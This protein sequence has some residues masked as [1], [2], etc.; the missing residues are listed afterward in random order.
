MLKCC[1]RV[2][3]DILSY[4]FNP[5]ILVA[6]SALAI[7]IEVFK[8]FLILFLELIVGLILIEIL[9]KAMVVSKANEKV[10]MINLKKLV[11]G[12]IKRILIYFLNTQQ[13]LCH[14]KI[15]QL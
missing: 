12:Q 6:D 9:F 1:K 3:L 5:N 8:R 15:N 10:V 7:T 2:G 11:V 13:P 4:E 14:E